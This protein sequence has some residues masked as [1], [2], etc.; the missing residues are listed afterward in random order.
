LRFRSFRAR[1]AAWYFTIIA[2][3]LCVFGAGSLVAIKASLYQ[4]IDDSLSDRIQG[5]KRFMDVQISALSIN[6]IR[7]EFREHSILGP[8]GDLFQ[9]CDDRGAW[10]YR[11]QPLESNQVPIRL[12]SQLGNGPAREDI[13]VANTPL[14]VAS[15]R[16]VV[17]GQPYTVQVAAPIGE[18]LE[19]L[20]RFRW[21]L[22]VFIPIVLLASSA[23]GYLVSRRAL[24]P[25]D[26]ISATARSI[27]IH[28][29]SERLTVPRTGDELERLSETLNGMLGRLDDSV[30]RMTQFTAD[31]SHEL[32]APVALIRATA[33]LTVERRRGPEEYESAMKDV[34][35]EAERTTHLLDS[36]L[37]LA[38]GDSGVD[39]LDL[40]PMDLGEAVREAI[41]ESQKF[42]AEKNIG[43]DYR[44]VDR[45]L[46][47]D[48]DFHTVR[49]LFVILIDNAVKY[50][51]PGGNIRVTVEANGK[52]AVAAVSDTGIGIARQD[53]AHIFDRFWRVDKVRSRAGG[54][55]GLG[56]SIARWIVDQH[57]GTIE[58]ESKPGLGTT[59]R[60][61]F[62]RV[63][64][65][66]ERQGMSE[67]QAS[68][69][70]PPPSGSAANDEG[71]SRRRSS[72]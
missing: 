44:M 16:I 33:E 36:L 57:H 58:V 59:F 10:L 62:P 64:S 31:A 32:R 72:V 39:T 51:N 12:P 48:G 60:I 24:K 34:L 18:I 19:S 7:D 56:L 50:T 61:S 38:R 30:R 49:R 26:E 6:E 65:G 66:L 14:R 68:E 21:M 53:Q 47:I 15:Q 9:V 69:T 17:S 4:S 70:P 3:G 37:T 46:E 11:S 8:G 54:G 55:A 1:L 40:I 2:T 45:G 13:R 29:L 22:V 27:S 43:V 41:E 63:V 67:T 35:L 28:N 5:I 52:L 20:E 25:V 71:D 42:A 23:G